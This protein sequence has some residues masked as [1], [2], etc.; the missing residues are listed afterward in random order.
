[1]TPNIDVHV[2]IRDNPNPEHLAQCLGS[3]EGQP[4]N[5]HTLPWEPGHIGK[6]RIRGYAQGSSPWVC[7][8]DDDDAVDE[9]LFHI[10]APL[11][12]DS[13]GALSTNVRELGRHVP[14][15]NEGVARFTLHNQVRISEH[16]CIFRRDLLQPLLPLYK[17]YARGGDQAVLKAYI[18]AVAPL[19][20]DGVLIKGRKYQKRE[21]L[22]GR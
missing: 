6:G 12:D 17:D 8:V 15:L 3:L 2:L 4:I 13:V 21:R 7:Y 5:L 1:M 14:E 16:L 22:C 11:L 19:R 9:D 18:N 10:A 20:L